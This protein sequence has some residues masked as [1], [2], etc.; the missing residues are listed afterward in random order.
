MR[1][2][3]L[4]PRL[5]ESFDILVIGG[6][7][8]GLGI[9]VDAASRGYATALIEAGDFAN[10]TSSRSTK[11]IHGG[12]RYL[13][14]CDLRL[15]REALRERA[16]LKRNAPHSVHDLGFLVPAY[17]AFESAYY[18]AGLKLYDAFAGQSGFEPSCY[19]S[20]QAALERMP[21]LRPDRLHGAIR[22][23][24][25]QFD[26]ARLAIALAQTAV[27][28]GAIVVN[29]VRAMSFLRHDE[30]ICGVLAR[31]EEADGEF[32][33]RARVVINATGIFV[34][35][36][37]SL[38]EP[39]Q[40]RLLALSRGSHVVF[41]R[42]VLESQ[43]ALLVPRTDDGR[44]LFAI[45]WHEHVLVGTT[46]VLANLPEADPQPTVAEIDFIIANFNRYLARPVERSG[47]RAAFAG[48]RPLV[49]GSAS[50]TA[51]LSREHLIDVSPQHLVTIAG[52]KWTTYRKMAQDA[53]DTAA[54]VSS[55]PAAPCRT[56]TLALHEL[57]P[58]VIDLLVASEP[59]LGALLH[60][61]LP[62]R[63][64]DVV[65]SIRHEMA[66]T[67]EDLLARRTRARFLDAA[68]AQE[69]EPLVAALLA[70]S[71]KWVNPN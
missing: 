46:D 44:V 48:L 14:S 38:D 19:F 71:K 49:H 4:L 7:A 13:Q 54:R 63:T 1:R 32:E 29:Y 66:R 40:P 9:A 33:I 2:E 51:R 24:D 61:R 18:F 50:S 65:Y 10:S 8:T 70:E 22:Y 64:A 20:R 28:H 47:V 27:A 41:D 3:A 43:D 58:S 56:E 53:V 67:A 36:I 26:D 42:E 31:D 69:A 25:G 12:V 45:P 5:Q 30:R 57:D 39:G 15:V 16:I 17:S 34:D 59:A 52:G 23:H 11:L 60:P 6:G 68:A 35:H 62:Y 37:R 21:S 55:L